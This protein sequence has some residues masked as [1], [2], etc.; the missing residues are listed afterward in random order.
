MTIE[1]IDV[2]ATLRKVEKLL[3]EEKGLSP[4]VRSMIELLVLLITLLARRLN[5]NS[6]NSSKPPSRDPNRKRESKAKGERKAGGQKGRDGVTLK[7][8]DNPDEV[9]V[10]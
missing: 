7:K 4:A 2:D 5:R 6:R 8:V 1:N 9:E 3:S 10:I